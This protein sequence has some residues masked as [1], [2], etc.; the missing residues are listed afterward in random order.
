MKAV[1][2]SQG[3]NPDRVAIERRI[4]ELRSQINVANKAR[5]ANEEQRAT[6]LRRINAQIKQLQAK[7]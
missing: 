5:Y 4:K 6:E 2:R 3:G 7:L 1:K